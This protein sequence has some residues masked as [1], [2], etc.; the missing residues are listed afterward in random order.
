[1]GQQA[2]A[3]YE[4]GVNVCSDSMVALGMPQYIESHAKKRPFEMFRIS[5]YIGIGGNEIINVFSRL[6]AVQS[7]KDIEAAV[8]IF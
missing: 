3:I 4:G 5:G 6:L 1:M 2:L 8:G 7:F